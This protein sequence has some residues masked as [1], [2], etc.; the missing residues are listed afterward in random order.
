V[1]SRFLENAGPFSVTRTMS[2]AA[3]CA[4]RKSE[5]G[6]LRSAVASIG[7]LKRILSHAQPVGRIEPQS[8]RMLIGRSRS[9]IFNELSRGVLHTKNECMV[10]CLGIEVD[11]ALATAEQV[12]V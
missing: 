1:Q 9:L 10:C 7:G 4:A 6:S 12:D 8:Y 5:S 11:D 2:P 3:A